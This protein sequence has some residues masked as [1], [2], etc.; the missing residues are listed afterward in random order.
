MAPADAIA[1]KAA[2]AL[3][4]PF[5]DRSIINMAAEGT[6][7]SADFIRR[8]EQQKTSSFH[9]LYMST[10]S[11]P[12]NDQVHRPVGGYPTGGCRGAMHHH[13]PLRYHG[14]AQPVRGRPESLHP[15]S[16]W[17]SAS[18][19]VREEYKVQAPDLRLYILKQDKNRAASHEHFTRRT[20][21]PRIT[22]WPS[23]AVLGLETIAS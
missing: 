21:R 18:W 3:G 7:L 12:V 16:P 20:G 4:T 22:I 1:C 23:A 17:R 19:R 15:R 5:F 6:G 8:T 2:E 13:G 10:Q 11:L 9:N 14:A